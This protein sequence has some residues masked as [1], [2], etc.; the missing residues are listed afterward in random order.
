MKGLVMPEEVIKHYDP[1]R[2]DPLRIAKD[3]AEQMIHMPGGKLLENSE[4]DPLS[5]Q[6]LARAI[7][8]LSLMSVATDFRRA[9]ELVNKYYWSDDEEDV[10][11]PGEKSAQLPA[12]PPPAPE[13]RDPDHH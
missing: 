10:S 13:Q 5:G 1:L 3:L 11:F 7:S 12:A 8:C 4:G 6:Q 9:L 2:T